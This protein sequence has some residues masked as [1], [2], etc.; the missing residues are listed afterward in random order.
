MNVS[1]II[2]TLQEKLNS[3]GEST[4]DLMTYGK[5]IEKLKVGAVTIVATP[6]DIPVLDDDGNVFLVQ[7]EN[8]LYYNVGSTFKSLGK[9]ID[10]VIYSWGFNSSGQLGNGT[11]TNRSSPGT[12]VGG[13]TNWSQVAAG[14]YHSLGVTAS[15]I[16]YAWGYNGRGRLGDG[17]TTDRSSPV[18][19]LGGITNWA[20]V[21][22]GTDHS[23]GVTASGIAYAWGYNS[24]GRLGDGTTTSRTSP[25]TVV[26]GITN[27]AQLDGGFRHS[28]GVTASGIAYAWG[29]GTD[30]RL[31]DGY[32]SSR[33]SPVTVI[34]GI[35]NWAQVSAGTSH[36]LGV[37]ASGIAYAWGLNS[38]GQ[39]GDGTTTNRS[40]P[41]TVIGGITNWAQVSGGYHSLGVTASGIAYAWGLNSTGQL[42]DGTTTNR[43]SPVTVVGGITNWAEVSAGE[44]ANSFSARSSAGITDNGLLYAWGDNGS[45]QLGDGTTTSRTSPVTVVG[46]ITNW[47]QVSGGADFMLAVSSSLKSFTQ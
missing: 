14:R 5:I 34:G 44:A 45:G 16:A 8:T 23:L 7:S 20:Q 42:G 15:G 39:L 12:V 30:G 29:V 33:T 22:A 10:N 13:I 31:G 3:S 2:F 11:T 4:L 21:F 6:F 26:G 19:V 32:T 38:T 47:A 17:T 27:W 36:S 25:V 35:T 24:F 43:S 28:L 40:S 46:G 41:V 37:T 9:I 18:T 1:N